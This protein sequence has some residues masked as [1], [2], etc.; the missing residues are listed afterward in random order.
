VRPLADLVAE[1]LALRA[2]NLGV[3]RRLDETAWD[4]RGIANN[5]AISVRGLV[6]VLAGHTRHHLDILRERYGVAAA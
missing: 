5:N 4:Q 1:L 3:V 2:I 6:Y